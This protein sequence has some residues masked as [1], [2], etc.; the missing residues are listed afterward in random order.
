ME[1]F[2]IAE[3]KDGDE[4]SAVQFKC[5]A[6]GHCFDT[7]PTDKIRGTRIGEISQ[8]RCPCGRY[9]GFD[10]REN[11]SAEA[12]DMLRELCVMLIGNLKQT[13]ETQRWKI[14][15]LMKGRNLKLRFGVKRVQ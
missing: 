5:E 12:P 3:V 7:I 15:E 4:I 10:F 14:G 2:D 11:I 13:T 8:T 6:C 9:S 1:C